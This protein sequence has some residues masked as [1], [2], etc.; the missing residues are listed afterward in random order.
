[1]PLSLAEPHRAS[2]A[3][4]A[5]TTIRLWEWGDPADPL[6]VMVHGGW[7]HGRM[8]DGIAPEVAGR[9]F[10]AV[11]V[12]LRGHGDSGRL[13]DSGACWLAW[14]LDLASLIGQ[15]GA[16]AGL[17]GHSMGGG[18]VLSVASAF[19][20]L[21]RWVLNLDGLGPG[22]EMM[23][24]E[25]HAAHAAQWLAD[26]EA[27]WSKP[28]REYPTIDDLARRRT[29]INIR[30]PFEWARH[31]ALHGSKRGPGGGYVWKSD[32]VMRIGGPGLLGEESLRAG[33]RQ[34][35]CPVTVLIG[36]EPDTWSDLP[37]DVAEARVAC[38]PH[39]TLTTV[40][41][42]GHYLH[43]ERPDAVLA[44]LDELVARAR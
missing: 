37:R 1:V 19:P 31:L 12:D 23:I 42:A 18:Q 25:D 2:F 41:G 36:E 32:A 39:G 38:F 40:P 11:A 17:I 5:R 34:I 6:V 15:L 3:Q 29:E 30:L 28:Q 43:I 24:V 8:W 27:V 13:G 26:A 33:Y 44:A 35:R 10:H 21:V 7:D 4:L 9:G 14:N 22:P 20:E 16:P